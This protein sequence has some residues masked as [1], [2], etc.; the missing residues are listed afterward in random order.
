MLKYA[1][2]AAMILAGPCAA[3]ETQ[4]KLKYAALYVTMFGASM[5][6]Y[7]MHRGWPTLSSCER[8]ISAIRIGRFV[9]VPDR[10]AADD[11][12]FATMRQLPPAS[13]PQPWEGRCLPDLPGCE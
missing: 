8:A 1:L 6:T 7:L 3:Q 2:I 5:D 4:Q 10:G 11:G 13:Q 12:M 9:C